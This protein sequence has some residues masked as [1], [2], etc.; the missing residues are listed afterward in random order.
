MLGVGGHAQTG[1]GLPSAPAPMADV[2]ATSTP[3][4]LSIDDAIARGLANN[5]QI[6]LSVQNERRVQGEVLTV[7][8]ALLPSLTAQGN[9]TAKELN[10]AAMGFKPST[11]SSFGITNFSSIIKVDTAAAQL[12]LSQ[13][14]FN[15]PAYY[16]YRGAQ[17][18][19]AAASLATLNV[20]GGITLQVATAYLRALADDAQITNARAL[21]NADQV[22]L[23]QAV[24][25]HDAGVGI[26]LDVL[27]ARVQQQQQQQVL[28]RDENA[29]AKDKISLN[30]LIGLSAGQVLTLTDPVPFEE[31]TALPLPEARSLAYTRRKDYLQLEAELEV[32]ERSQKAVRY[33]YLPTV[34]VGGYYG[35]IG[36]I[37]GL[38]HGNFVF[39][40]GITIPV[41]H[42]AE[43][44]GER[45]VAAAQTT[46]LR[47]Q[48]AGLR[49]TID[50]QLRDSMLDIE[51]SRDLVR[52][53]R[54]NVALAGDVLDDATERFKVGVSDNL[55]VVQAQATLAGAQTRL[56]QTL[57]QY[58]T[59]K[60]LLARNTGVVETQ[61]R[62]YLGK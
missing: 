46:G 26:N 37:G 54:S 39:Q 17:K 29:F 55:P 10:L 48:I 56:V 15:V 9:I 21:L 23:D 8:N 12:N 28:I 33:E 18:A 22:V 40:G 3:L 14:L 44:R 62:D 13:Q 41:F 32:A 42:E 20:R 27:R 24:A 34:A 52:V 60:L 19:T 11:L 25:S 49:E 51:S 43:F 59:A 36:V 5:L 57:Y 2:A 61:Y 4:P 31:L 16:L 7:G 53:A 50:A 6:A 1:A 58:N 45:E 47:R 35:V 30:R 38:Y